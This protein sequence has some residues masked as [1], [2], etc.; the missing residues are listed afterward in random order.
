MR[1]LAMAL[2]L[3]ALAGCASERRPR[4]PRLEEEPPP[5]VMPPAPVTERYR[6]AEGSLWHGPKS[7]RLLA[8]ENR[9]TQIGDVVT[10]MIEESARAE[11]EARTELERESDIQATVDSAVAEKGYASL[12]IGLNQVG[13]PV[14]VHVHQGNGP[15]ER[16]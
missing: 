3:L 7:Q 5:Q 14:L 6:P 12:V 11:N 15:S 13:I 16:G 9:A 8:F 1:A 2:A 4:L 10:V